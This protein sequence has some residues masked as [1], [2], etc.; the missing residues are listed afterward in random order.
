MVANALLDFVQK[1]VPTGRKLKILLYGASG[2]GKTRAALTFPRPLLVDAEGGSAFYR[3][4]PGVGEFLVK[5]TK[6]LSDLEK[7]ISLVQADNGK[8]VD[9]LIVDPITVFYD[10]QKDAMARTA[11]DGALGFREWARINNRMKAIY[12]SLTNLPVHVIVIARESVEYEG[13]G[14]NLKKVGQKPDSDKALPYVFDFSIRMNADHSGVVVKSRGLELAKNNRLDKVNWEAFQ[15]VLGSTNGAQLKIVDDESV[16]ESEAALL[17]EE[18]NKAA[19]KVVNINKG[20]ETLGSGSMERRAPYDTPRTNGFVG[21]NALKEQPEIEQ[22]A[23]TETPP[24]SGDVPAD[25]TP[26]ENIGKWEFFQPLMAHESVKNAAPDSIQRKNM[27]AL[28][29]KN[30]AFNSGKLS[31]M[32]WRIQTYRKLRTEG[33]DEADAARAAATAPDELEGFGE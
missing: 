26:S 21:N 9:T 6:A 23:E 5:D 31:S 7:I 20:R 2:S 22:P 28:L 11:K 29:K 14:N 30:G 18:E 24:P 1:A 25:P 10:V 8:T 4:R 16:V 3:G 17:V 33:F 27:I 15:P 12:N 13:E 19:N 32:V